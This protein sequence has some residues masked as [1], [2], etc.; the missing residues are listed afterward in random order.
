MAKGTKKYDLDERLLE[1]SASVI[2]LVEDMVKRKR[3]I[4]WEANCCG[5][6][7]LLT[8][9]TERRKGP[10]PQEIPYIKC[11]CV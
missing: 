1:Y 6:A 10:N 7:P 8:S 2:R 11:P 4:M 9:I 5:L 3:A